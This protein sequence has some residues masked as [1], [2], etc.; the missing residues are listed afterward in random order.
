MNDQDNRINTSLVTL[1]S[2]RVVNLPMS[3]KNNK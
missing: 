1:N 2:P 3:P